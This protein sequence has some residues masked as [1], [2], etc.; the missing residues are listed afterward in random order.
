MSGERQGSTV[1]VPN[2]EE[3]EE[4]EE[5]RNEGKTQIQQKRR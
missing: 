4:A 1:H 2:E 5:G 3:E